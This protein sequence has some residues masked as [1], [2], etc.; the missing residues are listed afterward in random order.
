MRDAIGRT[1]IGMLSKDILIELGESLVKDKPLHNKR[2]DSSVH[3]FF[4]QP[5]ALK[6]HGVI[7]LDEIKIKTSIKTQTISQSIPMR[8]MKRSFSIPFKRDEEKGNGMHRKNK[9]EIMEF[10]DRNNCFQ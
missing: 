1:A 8:K 4:A 9:S 2:R 7:V 10:E 6:T 5:L 3:D